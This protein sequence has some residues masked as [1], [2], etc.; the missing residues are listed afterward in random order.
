MNTMEVRIPVN[1]MLAM[2]NSLNWHDRHWLVEQM[3]AQFD[4]EEAESKKNM[5]ELR[6]MAS[7][8]EERDNSNLDAFLEK[9]SGDWGGDA[10][11]EDLAADLRQGADMVRNVEVW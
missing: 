6:K 1:A 11:V 9:I 7:T 5:E 2:L 4:R 10:S 3:T 8:W